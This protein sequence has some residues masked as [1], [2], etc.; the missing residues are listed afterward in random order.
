V[1]KNARTGNHHAR[2]GCAG[3]DAR[4]VSSDGSGRCSRHKDGDIAPA[5]VRETFHN[6]GERRRR[7]VYATE[8]VSL[9]ELVHAAPH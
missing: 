2:T 3:T 1:D 8:S 4:A 7:A 9:V 5:R 6:D